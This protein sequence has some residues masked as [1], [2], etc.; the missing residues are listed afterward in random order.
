MT[1][2]SSEKLNLYY[3]AYNKKRESISISKS[4][5]CQTWIEGEIYAKGIL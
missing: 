2:V 1:M 4:F 5:L 3:R